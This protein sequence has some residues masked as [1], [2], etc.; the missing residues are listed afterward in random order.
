MYPTEYLYYGRKIGSEE[1]EE[2]LLLTLQ[3]PISDKQR[4][5]V[6]ALMQENGYDLG[7][8]RESVIVFDGTVPDFTRTIN[9]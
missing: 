2:E 9:R 8:F 1:W 7:T 3:Q 6:F 4:A 5:H